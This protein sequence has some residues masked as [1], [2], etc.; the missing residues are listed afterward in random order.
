VTAADVVTILGSAVDEYIRDHRNRATTELQ[1][2]TTA[3]DSDED[4]VECAALARFPNRTRH[5]HQ[6]RVARMALKESRCR[7]LEILPEL[8]A[9][10]SFDGLFARVE[11]RIRPIRGIG[12]LTVYDTALRI[13]ARFGLEPARVYLHAGTRVGATKLGVDPR[14]RTIDVTEFPAPMARLSAREAEDLLC[15]YKHRFG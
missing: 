15:I 3:F 12:E 10:T 4:A 8:R 6:R 9:S 11:A 5:P 13:G 14:R 2:F 7:L 1:V